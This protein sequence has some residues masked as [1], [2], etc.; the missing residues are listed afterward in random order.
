VSIGLVLGAVLFSR[1]TTGIAAAPAD[2]GPPS[3]IVWVV[4]T[5][6]DGMAIALKALRNS[7]QRNVRLY[8]SGVKSGVLRD[9]FS[10]T[11]QAGLDVVLRD[12][13]A[14][15]GE[16][17]AFRLGFDGG[18]QQ[19]AD[20]ERFVIDFKFA[21]AGSLVGAWQPLFERCALDGAGPLESYGPHAPA[22]QKG[23]G[24]QEPAPWLENLDTWLDRFDSD[25]KE[26]P[27]RV[28]VLGPDNSDA[29]PALWFHLA[30]RQPKPYPPVVSTA[31]TSTLLR[32]TSPLQCCDPDDPRSEHRLTRGSVCWLT[33]LSR[34]AGFAANDFS[35]ATYDQQKVVVRAVERA[36]DAAATFVQYPLE[37]DALVR[38]MIR[39]LYDVQGLRRVAILYP[40]GLAED[41]DGGEG[42][43]GTSARNRLAPPPDRP[44][45]RVKGTEPVRRL[46]GPSLRDDFERGYR[47]RFSADDPL[48]SLITSSIFDLSSSPDAP[49]SR[50]EKEIARLRRELL[51]VLRHFERSGVQAVGVFGHSDTKVAVLGI[52]QE[53]LPSALLFTCDADWSYESPDPPRP[54]P[55][56]EGTESAGE[57]ATAKKPAE[58]KL[59]GLMVFT[60]PEPPRSWVTSQF[61]DLN[62]L[63]DG[64]AGAFLPDLHA[65][66]TSHV[67]K[68]LIEMVEAKETHWLNNPRHADDGDGRGGPTEVDCLECFLRARTRLYGEQFDATP[69]GGVRSREPVEASGRGSPQ[70]LIIRGGRL[71]P[72][73]EAGMDGRS[74]G[75]CV[76]VFLVLPMVLWRFICARG[77]A[78]RIEATQAVTPL[79]WLTALPT[80]LGP[81]VRVRSDGDAPAVVGA[82]TV[83]NGRDRDRDASE[84][85][86]AGIGAPARATPP[87]LPPPRQ[88]RR[89]RR[90]GRRGSIGLPTAALAAGASPLARRPTPDVPV[91]PGSQLLR[92][93]F[94]V[95]IVIALISSCLVLDTWVLDLQI[96]HDLL[97]DHHS[98]VPSVFL[99]GSAAVLALYLPGRFKRQ[100]MGQ[101]G[102][103]AKEGEKVKRI[104]GLKRW[105]PPLAPGDE[106]RF[107][108]ALLRWMEC[109]VFPHLRPDG[110][111]LVTS[112]AVAGLLT[113]TDALLAGLPITGQW[114]RIP[115]IA[116][117]DPSWGFTWFGMVVFEFLVIQVVVLTACTFVELA[118]AVVRL[119]PERPTAEGVAGGLEADRFSLAD[120]AKFEPESVR[121]LGTV[122]IEMVAFALVIYALLLVAR[123]PQLGMARWRWDYRGT[124]LGTM[125]FLAGLMFVMSYW[126]FC[127]T[128]LGHLLR[129]IKNARLRELDEERLATL[130]KLTDDAQRAA[131]SE[132]F[133]GLRQ[134]VEAI[135]ERPWET[136]ESRRAW[137]A[138]VVALAPVFLPFL[139]GHL[140]ESLAKPLGE[141][142]KSLQ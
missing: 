57:A 115:W 5:S 34:M 142:I 99:M 27:G 23:S 113:A 139:L 49:D 100:L 103:Q 53:Q 110:G 45:F 121:R 82:V 116:D 16:P 2:T 67:V 17:F 59:E 91:P 136:D 54:A 84:T 141:A 6:T 137:I 104:W 109:E 1:A 32:H 56:V 108:R 125:V 9:D 89:H 58:Y 8:R 68:R 48:A 65:F 25:L 123:L 128:S 29:A 37:G 129:R 24:A 66:Y 87:A 70:V 77:S 33:A 112:A 21:R 127:Y 60:S 26:W 133:D 61:K 44:S 124:P 107:D 18:P 92:A 50:R 93:T 132:R 105:S 131:E 41:V 78:R 63:A 90:R 74:W 30:V 40:E 39:H 64:R 10:V 22:R 72:I 120:L 97:P 111:R 62:A 31:A 140:G 35:Q 12:L 86:S 101:A 11:E 75:L 46:F 47:R 138:L 4:D 122:F 3:L 76:A 38:G 28:L 96:S 135:S 95:G 55:A 51:P 69:S 126:Y 130:R 94:L 88:S 73:D 43:V 106:E 117:A 119:A 36:Q 15:N 19:G 79:E 14:S 102:F 134:K 81:H 118:R 42:V 114:L 52:V 20:R 98:I 13:L 71:R 80:R 85:I 83:V 7:H